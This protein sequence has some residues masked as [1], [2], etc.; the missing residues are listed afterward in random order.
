ME[1]IIYGTG[2]AAQKAYYKLKYEHSIIGFCDSNSERWGKEFFGLPIMSPK[3]AINTVNSNIVI[4]S[5]YYDEIIKTLL[6]EECEF[7]RIWYVR[8]GAWLL[9]RVDQGM[10][11][12]VNDKKSMKVLFVQVNPNIRI[13]KIAFALKA[14]GV[15]CDL[16]Y[17]AVPP[18]MKVGMKDMPFN[19]VISINNLMDFIQYVN[20]SD[21]DVVYSENE[22]DYLTALML[23]SNKKVIHDNADM[24]SLRA[25][26]LI[27][28]LIYEYI[29]NKK[30]DANVYVT[31]K[32]RDIAFEKYGLRGKKTLVLN[33][34]VLKKEKPT[35]F[36]KK[37]SK[38]DGE[39]HCVY[40]GSY[41]TADPKDHRYYERMFMDIAERGIHVHFYAIPGE[42]IEE[43]SKKHE[44]IH[45]EGCLG[46]EELLGELTQYD[47]GLVF[48]N[49]TKRNEAFLQTTFSNKIFEYLFAGLPVAVSDIASTKEFVRKY[50]VGEYLDFNG[51]VKAQLEEISRYSIPGDF[52]ESN[53]LTMDD[54][55]DE[56]IRFLRDVIGA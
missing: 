27:G 43:L 26:T 30:S 3:E 7:E 45:Y 20:E 31:E 56:I 19:K 54:Q 37:L 35:H 29:A 47:I 28:D 53:K 9:E 2:M 49:I 52:L 10:P 22:P 55:A 38:E 51:D 16:A 8:S 39:L 32:I 24:M 5:M 21:Y 50:K 33:N 48:L 12:A 23:Q 4:A 42:Y 40:E 13:Y 15:W 18:E 6:D 14:K 44:Y 46:H 36:L 34:Y 11:A 41:I 1:I 25:D 17:L